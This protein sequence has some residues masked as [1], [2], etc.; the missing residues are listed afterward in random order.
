MPKNEFFAAFLIAHAIMVIHVQPPEFDQLYRK[1]REGYQACINHPENGF[2]QEQVTLP[3]R[4][5]DVREGEVKIV[6]SAG[7]VEVDRMEVHLGL[8]ASG[9]WMGDYVAIL[10]VTG[11]L[12]DERLV[13]H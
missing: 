13:F 4:K 2:L 10:N 6:F 8:Y 5:I 1:A 12:V 11:E 9:E 3:L 7:R